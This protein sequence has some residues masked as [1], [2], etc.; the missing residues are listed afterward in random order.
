MSPTSGVRSLFHINVNCT[1]MERTVRFYEALGF[2]VVL[3]AGRVEG[4]ADQSYAALGVTGRFAH[5]GP[6]V[7]FLG[8]DLYQTRLDVMQWI[9]PSPVSVDPL[10]ANTTTGVNR[11]ALRVRGLR[12]LYARLVGAGFEFLTPPA[13]PFEDRAIAAIVCLRD[14][15]GLLVELMEFLSGGASLYDEARQGE[16]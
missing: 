1:D 10:R 8:D 12:E 14:P 2:H 7:M 9:V 3:D 13:G 5:R 6:V 15:D 4:D 16:Q 11:I